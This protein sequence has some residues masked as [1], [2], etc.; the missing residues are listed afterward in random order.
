MVMNVEV[1][2]IVRATGGVMSR[3]C[4]QDVFFLLGADEIA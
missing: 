3:A 4:H 2:A 1:L